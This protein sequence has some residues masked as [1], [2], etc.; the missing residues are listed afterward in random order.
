MSLLDGYITVPEDTEYLPEGS[1]VEVLLNPFQKSYELNFIGS[2]DP[3]LQSIVANLPGYDK[4]RIV[5]VGSLSGL[6]ALKSGVADLAGT[7]LLDPATGEYNL[8]IVR[9]LDIKHVLVLI[10]YRREQ[11]LMYRKNTGPVSSFKDMVHKHL[12]FVNRNPGSGTRVLIDHM[13]EEEARQLGISPEELKKRLTGYTFEVKTHEAVA[14]LISRGIVDVGIG[15]KYIAERYG[16]DFKPITS[17]RYDI[18][19][20]KEAYTNEIVSQIIDKIRS[21]DKTELPTGYSLDKKTGTI[22]EL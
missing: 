17:E 16:L 2:H 22:I 4:V 18:V 3:L 19:I 11:G 6:Q 20:R 1:E 14:Y 13:L 12:R 8:P 15:V 5:N 10:G 21:L 9:Q 7:H